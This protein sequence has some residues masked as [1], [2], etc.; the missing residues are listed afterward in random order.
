ME[1]NVL[2][3]LR[4][5]M[6]RKHFFLDLKENDRG[7]FLKVT[8]DV[9]GRRDTIMIPASGLEEFYRALGEI[10]DC[11]KQTEAPAV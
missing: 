3:S 2:K 5:E 1:M 7:V 6:E 10:V 9:Q 11:A 4:V 8:E